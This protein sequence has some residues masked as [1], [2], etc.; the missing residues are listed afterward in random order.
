M[1]KHVPFEGDVM[2]SQE[3]KGAL[4]PL[5]SQEMLDVLK[6][7]IAPAVGCTEVGAAALIAAK[8]AEAL[9]CMPETIDLEVSISIYKN[10]L[11][12]G[13]P[14]T[15]L[16]GLQYSCALGA[17]ICD[18]SL[19]LNVFAK[20]DEEN[21]AAAIEMVKADKISLTCDAQ[22]PGSIY[23][24]A[25]AKAAD[26][27]VTVTILGRHDK[28]V[29]VCKNGEVLESAQ[30]QQNTATSAAADEVSPT[31][32]L[33]AMSVRDILAQ[34]L[35]LDL[36]EADYLF[37]AAD[38]NREA[39][40]IGL[41]DKQST[42][43][44]ALMKTVAGDEQARRIS[45]VRAMTGASSEARMRG[46]PVQIHSIAGSGNHGITNFVGVDTYARE[47]G[48]SDD[49]RQRALAITSVLAIYVKAHA[50]RVSSYCGCAIAPGAGVAAASVYLEGGD[51]EK[52]VGAVQSVIGT[53]AGMLCD[54]A[55][56]SCAYKV[57]TVAAT[58]VQFAQLAMNG[59]NVEPGDGIVSQTIEQTIANLGTLN[60]PGMV[61]TDKTVI[62][63]LRSPV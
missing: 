36:S 49:V 33:K 3:Q 62:S 60:N 34:V 63:M 14:G 54:G 9:G 45:R 58:A 5:T 35:E 56:V 50:G 51:I 48:V 28:I 47:L 7:E 55:K 46:L 6:S 23:L 11:T 21:T 40:E 53:F 4:K 1:N 10:G 13:I 32:R 24:K 37:E 25:T 20:V 41:A 22:A 19:G 17:L 44:P 31:D 16:K 39:A 8:A 29:E 30:A 27:V 61:E 15:T 26:D 57:A 18:S 43:G 2:L 52:M 42:L 38:R 59:A 12:V